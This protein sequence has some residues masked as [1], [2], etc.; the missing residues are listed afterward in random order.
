MARAAR[1]RRRVIA[2]AIVLLT[3]ACGSE[4]QNVDLEHE[5]TRLCQL[6]VP[7]GASQ[8]SGF[9]VEHSNHRFETRWTFATSLDWGA[10]LNWLEASLP[11]EYER[12]EGEGSTVRFDRALP[13]DLLTLEVERISESE[14]MQV[15][16]RFS[17]L[18]F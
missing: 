12:K 18:A 7:P 4:V 11:A 1:C 10:L 13:A 17:A 6:S 15:E 8:R 2:L 16:V 3:L 14:P 9:P 5:A